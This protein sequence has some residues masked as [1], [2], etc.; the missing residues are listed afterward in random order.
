MLTARFPHQGPIT[1]PDLRLTPEQVIKLLEPLLTP[2]RVA[3]IRRVISHRT[4]SVVPVLEN[5][6]DRGNTS[7]V[8]RTAEALGYQ[9]VHVIETGERFKAANRVTQGADK[10]LDVTRWKSTTD[11]ALQLKSLGYKIYATQLDE[12]AVPISEIDCTQPLALVLGNEKDGVSRELLAHADASVIIPMEG[13]VQ[14]FNISVAA[15]I[16]LYHVYRERIQRLGN[17]GDLTDQESTVLR[18][19]YYL[20]SSK[21]PDRLLRRLLE[22]Q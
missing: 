2:E 7:A 18:A 6:Y 12:R 8:M 16:S 11:C 10:W 21:N 4:Y 15:A 20:R 1:A 14:S 5:I 22:R 17:Q 19:L 3:K 9:S 13:F